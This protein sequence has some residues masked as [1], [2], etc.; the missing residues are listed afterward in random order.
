MTLLIKVMS[1]TV[2]WKYSFKKLSA[3]LSK[4]HVVSGIIF[5]EKVVSEAD[6]EDTRYGRVHNITYT[7][8]QRGPVST[9]VLFLFYKICQIQPFLFC[10][11]CH[12]SS[13]TLKLCYCTHL[14]F[15][16]SL[17]REHNTIG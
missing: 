9:H 15:Q 17:T 16:G 14:P 1:A 7:T 12:P 13:I 3:K 11:H 5:W 10:F 6:M 4:N 2:M 8:T